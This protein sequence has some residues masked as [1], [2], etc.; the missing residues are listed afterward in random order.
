LGCSV[1]STYEP[2]NDCSLY[3]PHT[4]RRHYLSEDYWLAIDPERFELPVCTKAYREEGVVL[5]HQYLL[6]SRADM[7]EIAQAV[8][9]LFENREELRKSS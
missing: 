8:E 4:K 3:K 2:L 6:A 9:K 5:P 1:S 7:D